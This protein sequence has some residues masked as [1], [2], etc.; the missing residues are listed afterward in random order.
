MADKLDFNSRKDLE[1]WLHDKPPVW[2]QTL[3][4]RMALRVFPL[5]LSI[6]ELPDETLSVRHKKNL[7]LQAFRASCISWAARKYPAQ[8]MNLAAAAAAPATSSTATTVTYAPT[9][10]TYAA[11]VAAAAA[12]AATVDPAASTSATVDADPDAAAVAIAA[13]TATAAAAA[14]V[15]DASTTAALWAAINEDTNLIVSAENDLVAATQLIAMPLWI[16]ELTESA[17]YQTNSP[18]FARR[19]YDKFVNLEWVRGSSWELITDWYAAILPNGRGRRPKSLLGE[20]ADIA[21]ATQADDFWTVTDERSAER[22]LDEIAE[23]AGLN[24]RSA[25]E[26]GPLTEFITRFLEAEKEPRSIDDIRIALQRAD[27]EYI[28]K[29][30]RGALSILAKKDR[31]RRVSTGLYQGMITT[32]V[33]VPPSQGHGPYLGVKDGQLVFAPVSRATEAGTDFGR[34]RRYMPLVREALEEFLAATPPVTEGGNDPFHRDKRM[35]ERYLE[36]STIDIDSIDY[37]LL[38]GVG[39]SLM[40]RLAADGNRSLESDLPRLSDAQRLALENFQA[41]HGPLIAA[42]AAGAE[43][44]ADAEKV[45]RNPEEERKFRQTVLDFMHALKK[46][47]G[48]AKPEVAELLEDA[49]AEMGTGKQAERSFRFGQGGARNTAIVVTSVGTITALPIIGLALGSG[50]AIVAGVLSYILWE[51]TKKS[52]P[53]SDAIKPITGLLDNLSELDRQKLDY[54]IDSGTSERFARFAIKEEAR[55]RAI[56]GERPEFKW[57]H[58]Q[59]DFLKANFQP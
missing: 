15:N 51:A 48:L 30:M 39:T 53:F 14:L 41:G 33:P 56:A 28:D 55:L 31:I 27:Y 3:A 25:P 7:I 36:A 34:V 17:R 58:D 54:L 50:T 1:A 46:E 11:L 57:L 20:K 23:I 4:A 2:A 59:L 32:E 6:A 45:I 10:A 29:S 38:F 22:I 49:A 12:N 21:I 40:N 24:R 42:T 18:E 8:D 43:A 19:A 26:Q 35:A 44:I 16:G 47:Q 5:V 37:D 9:T 13:A 52:K